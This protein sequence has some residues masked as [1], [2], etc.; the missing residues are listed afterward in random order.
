[1]HHSTVHQ[2]PVVLFGAGGVGRA[3]LQQLLSNREQVAA[4]NRL[5]FNILAVA[6][7]R[8][9]LWDR[10]GLEDEP[11][12]DAL[13][14]KKQGR[15]L[16]A[17][18]RPDDLQLLDAVLAAAPD[19]GLVVDVTAG[20][21]APLL[22][23]ALDRRCGVV[24]ANKKPL[25]GPWE[26]ARRFYHNPLVRYES[27]V[28]GG[29]PLAATLRT[30]LDTGD[31]VQQIDGQLSG[32]LGYICRRLDEGTPF[33]VALAAARAQGRT[34]PDPRED[35]GGRDVARKLMILGRT[36]GWPLE[37]GDI[38][39]ESL[40]PQAL[41]HLAVDEFMLASVAMDPP[42][43]D[44][45]NAAGAAGE[46][47]RYVAEVAEGG[48]SV[49]LQ[50]VPMESPLAALK[51]VRFH[52]NRYRDRH[53]GPLLIGSNTGGLEPTAAGVFADMIG[54]AREMRGL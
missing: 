35:L 22:E 51:Y 40:F 47:L 11:L 5:R 53:G 3:L 36:A 31:N 17:A 45:A 48:G 9:W 29:Q 33:S 16:S 4:R 8:S 34:E 2:V 15:P 1:M 25:A 14:A 28:G 27:T 23:R 43:R 10:R 42:L 46:V 49:G 21:M 32:T 52:T 54:L 20:E 7:S 26:R 39:V 37:E 19:A 50:P 12:R 41:A 30:L 38:S 6:D 24:L 13:S 18:E 44:R